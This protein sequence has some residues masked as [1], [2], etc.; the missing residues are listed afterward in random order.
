[1]PFVRNYYVSYKFTVYDPNNKVEPNSEISGVLWIKNTG[2]KDKKLKKVKI[3]VIETYDQIVYELSKGKWA[4]MIK[5][6]KR[7]PI[8]KGSILKSGEIKEYEFK[9]ILP[10]KWKPKTKKRFK[11]WR[12]GLGLDIKKKRNSRIFPG[13]EL[14]TG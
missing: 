4:P 5:V 8:E 11:N 1:M 6:L 10:S 13:V 9:I 2:K 7:Y 12:L 14:F 3:V